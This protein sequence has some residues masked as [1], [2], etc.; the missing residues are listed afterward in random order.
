M[1]TD[2]LLSGNLYRVG[3]LGE[4]PTSNRTSGHMAHLLLFQQRAGAACT[5]SH[6]VV[7]SVVCIIM[8]CGGCLSCETINSGLL[9]LTDLR[10]TSNDN[11]GIT[12]SSIVR[13][14]MLACSTPGSRLRNPSFSR[15]ISPTESVCSARTLTRLREGLQPRQ[16]GSDSNLDW[17]YA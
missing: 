1:M 8:K 3:L 6:T 10:S 9:I 4:T 7:Q 17:L 14:R 11:G 5:A 13:T 2:E 12:S 15:T 16:L